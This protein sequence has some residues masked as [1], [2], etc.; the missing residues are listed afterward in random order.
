[1]TLKEK[2]KAKKFAKQTLTIK[3]YVNDWY[4]KINCL[5]VGQRLPVAIGP[6]K[7]EG[8]I[9]SILLGIDIGQITLVEN[10]DDIYNYE[11]V[12]GGH[13][14]RYIWDYIQN[15]FS[16]DGKYFNQ[17]D[18]EKQK[19]FL[20]YEIVFSIY[21]PLDVYTKG[22]IFRALNETTKVEHQEMLNSYGNIPIA[23]F[24][25]ELVRSVS[26]VN[27]T[28]H[29]LFECSLIKNK[30]QKFKYLEF[31]N[32]RLKTEELVARIVY[33]YYADQDNLLGSSSDDDLEN[34]YE[35]ETI[36]LTAV[37]FEKKVKEHLNFLLRCANAKKQLE[38]KGL[39]QQDFKMLSFVYY[40]M[41]D[42]Y[43]KFRIDDYIPFIKA[44]RKAMSILQEKDGKY[45]NVKVDVDFDNSA[46][47]VPEA[48]AKYLGAPHHEKKIKQTVIW[49]LQE[50]DIREYVII[51]DSKRAYTLKEKLDQLA[52]Q[53]YKCKITGNDLKYEDAEAAH[54]I[55]H[56]NG[57]MSTKDNMV[58]IERE[59]NRAMGTMN[60]EDY[61]KILDNQA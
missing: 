46:R 27:N 24:I 37:S 11:S 18:Q 34:M 39:T 3:Q 33:R 42:N 59:H 44:Y 54:I 26:G 21:E 16:V 38:Q 2:I 41:L 10:S 50:F 13:R 60:L 51:Q 29:E 7:R 45:A 6:E 57:G 22:Y 14:K 53:D 55:S 19:A 49:L 23:N 28:T 36:D 8:I 31:N 9:R 61:R 4:T 32:L 48:F 58:M 25:R 56:H 43:G 15:K 35:D 40:H 5:P 12:D 52:V 1:M 47:L 20:N 17:L 30:E